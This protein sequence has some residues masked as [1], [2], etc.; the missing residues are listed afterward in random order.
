MSNTQD[1]NAIREI[2]KNPVRN[3]AV[4]GLINKHGEI[5]LVRTKRLP[6]HWQPIGG[7]IKPHD[8]TPAHTL[9]RELQ[10]ETGLQ[11]DIA[12]FRHAMT[13]DYDFGEGKVH[14]FTC[15]LSCGTPLEMNTKELE[16]WQWFTIQ[17]ALALEAFPATGKFLRY[18]A[19]HPA[20]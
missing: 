2:A 13:V 1:P 18:L 7:G 8:A 4:A 16:A 9:R 3:V 20:E 19:E 10:E 5:L 15:S 17:G 14:F 6:N 11:L 12:A